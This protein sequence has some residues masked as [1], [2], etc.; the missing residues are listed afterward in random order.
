[1]K[2]ITLITIINLRR[3]TNNRAIS[4]KS[5]ELHFGNGSAAVIA[6]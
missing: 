3:G 1:M 2:K 4:Y 6:Q 5:Q